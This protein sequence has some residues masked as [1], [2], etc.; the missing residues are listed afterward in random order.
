M[1]ANYYPGHITLLLLCG[2]SQ[3]SKE[4]FD[5]L[6]QYGATVD[7]RDEL[8]RTCLHHCLSSTW[9][10]ARLFSPDDWIDIKRDGIIYL[11]ERGA[12]MFAVDASGESVSG[13]AC[14]GNS[15]ELGNV[16][17]HV[18]DCVLAHFGHPLL[19]PSRGHARVVDCGDSYRKLDFE[20]LWKGKEDLCPYYHEVL[21]LFDEQLQFGQEQEEDS[22]DSSTDSSDG[23]ADL[24]DLS[25][26]G[27]LR[28]PSRYHD[29]GD[30]KPDEGL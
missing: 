13:I 23:G 20:R 30:E 12:D 22:D 15:I 19:E 8:G 10:W 17:E 9:M 18:W 1:D 25:D 6:F 29:G 5:L 28:D 4:S 27:S 24:D 26:S 2:S 7:S 14:L 16:K 3:W 21:P 11:I